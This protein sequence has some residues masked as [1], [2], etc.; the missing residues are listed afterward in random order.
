MCSDSNDEIEEI[1]HES[2]TEDSNL[3]LRHF[4]CASHT[5]NLIA[6]TDARKVIETVRKLM[7]MY[8]TII[9]KCKLIWK[10]LK[11][12]K[13]KEASVHFIG[14]SIKQPNTT[15]WNSWYD[16]LQQIVEIHDYVKTE[17]F[18][19]IISVNINFKDAD[20]SYIK[21]YLKIME[22]LANAIDSLQGGENCH[23]GHLLPTLIT[24][25]QRWLEQIDT[26]NKG[27]YRNFIQGMRKVLKSR[28]Q[29]M[30][31][32]RETGEVAAIAALSHPSCKAEWVKCLHV[33]A[34]H[35]VEKLVQIYK[36][37]NTAA[38]P[39]PPPTKNKFFFGK[40]SEPSALDKMIAVKTGSN[41]LLCFLAEPVSDCLS[42][43]NNFPKLRELF[44]KYNTILPSSAPV[45]RLFSYAILL[46]MP[47]YNRLSDEQFE[48]RVVYKIQK[49]YELYGILMYYSIFHDII[50][51]WLEIYETITIKEL[52]NDMLFNAETLEDEDQVIGETN[53]MSECIR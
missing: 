8:D 38:F 15:R 10:S 44:M 36:C 33:E 28:F 13:R 5:L 19:K 45:E 30:F 41:E 18:S 32:I 49:N 47:K 46:N 20:T 31:D 26:I 27:V 52:V 48:K 50:L 24:I 1:R 22:P 40:S 25:E 6:T 3:L 23:Y 34:Q 43:L 7:K 16:A 11:S 42:D 17:T 37:T 29:D 4:R 35:N 9:N 21:H 53:I 51:S 14:R 39:I 2:F 12:V